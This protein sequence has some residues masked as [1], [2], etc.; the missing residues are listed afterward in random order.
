MLLQVFNFDKE[1]KKLN[2]L[3]FKFL[4]LFYFFLGYPVLDK[5]ID[6]KNNLA[7]NVEDWN[8]YLMI[9]RVYLFLEC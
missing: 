2:N 9:S 3:K 8:K 6:F 1:K 5:R 7:T 4:F